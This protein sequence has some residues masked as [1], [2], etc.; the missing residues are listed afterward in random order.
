[1]ANRDIRRLVGFALDFRHNVLHLLVQ[2]G[3]AF[4][5]PSRQSVTGAHGLLYQ[6]PESLAELREYVGHQHGRGADENARNEFGFDE[7]CSQA[8]YR[9]GR[10]LVSNVVGILRGYRRGGLRRCQGCLDRIL[11]SLLMCHTSADS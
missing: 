1:M 5:C 9:D 2:F 6:R 8:Y 3:Y 10:Y 11:V 4:P 7:R